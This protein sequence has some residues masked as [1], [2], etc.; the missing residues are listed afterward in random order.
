MRMRYFPRKSWE[1]V[2][3]SLDTLRI[4]SPYTLRIISSDTELAIFDL[5]L[6]ERR[7]M[8]E[9]FDKAMVYALGCIGKAG[10]TVKE[11]GGELYFEW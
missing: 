6:R 2:Y 10:L 5:D 9:I 3:I 11:E 1:F 4:T 8:A 7:E